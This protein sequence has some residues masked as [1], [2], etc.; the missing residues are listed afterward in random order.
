MNSPAI[1]FPFNGLVPVVIGVTGHRDIPDSDVDALVEATRAALDEI[2]RFSPHS[3][4]VLLSSL[5][6]GADR[7]A[8][9]V[10]LERGWALGVILPGPA[11]IY[12]LDF[13]T[14]ESLTDFR[15]LLSKAA[16]VEEL[17]AEVMT[18]VA[19]R[20]AGLRIARQ[21]F[22]LL[23]YWDGAA[24]TSEG[25][26]ADIVDLFLH[27]IPE[28]RMAGAADNSLLEARPV[29]HIITRR[30]SNLD[31]IPNSDI[32]KLVHL[33]PEPEG[34][35]SE[36]EL[37][38]WAAVLR[39]IDQFNQDAAQCLVSDNVEVKKVRGRLDVAP[40]HELPIQA[41]RSATLHAIADAISM[42]TQA[43]RTMH[44]RTL[45]ALAICAIFSEQLYSGL[46][47]D[48][49]VLMLAIASGICAWL[50]Y[51]HGARI[52][53]ENRYLDYRALAEACRVQ[54]FWKRAGMKACVADHFLRD[55][56]DELE[57]IRRAVRT[58]ELMPGELA[59]SREQ[60]G[61]VANAW[62]D[63]QLHYFVGKSGES[64]GN[65]AG[66]NLVR[67]E[68]WT[69]RASLLFKA[70]IVTT[71]FLATFHFLYVAELGD[72]GSISIQII[73][74]A[75]GAM[76]ASAG[77]IKIHQEVNA[78]SEHANRYRRMGVAMTVAKQRLESAL[79]NNQL[80]EAEN[81]L[82]GAG[83]DALEENGGWLLLH[84]ER[85]VKVPIG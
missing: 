80:A 10:A 18:P 64:G 54:Y 85:P 17:P 22:Y 8:A 60:M 28:E 34:L 19:Y 38:R 63:G 47:T 56:R 68:V 53:L 61:S 62:L 43:R 65:S 58:T 51:M 21:A 42:Y 57:W 52:R 81:I 4:H 13:K 25:G 11:E 3:P 39:H 23:A 49:S 50:V 59:L 6:E 36:C 41:R 35:R 70:G 5:A 31:S 14:A 83:R 7:I 20:A 75:Y 32:G 24:T 12:A 33:A 69:G 16:W 79:S 29:W 55:Q 71:I 67:D 84:R 48:P 40:D 77:L 72:A 37:E 76:F 9:Q 26:T 82:L 45:F 30:Q 46:I 78:F 66:K 15:K 74:L 1:E 27:G 73:M 44:M 2:T